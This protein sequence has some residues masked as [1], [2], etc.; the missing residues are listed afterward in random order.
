MFFSFWN[1][2]LYD[3]VLNVLIIFFNEILSI[4]YLLLVFMYNFRFLNFVVVGYLLFYGE[5]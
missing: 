5:F 3:K 1:Y 4:K 2:F